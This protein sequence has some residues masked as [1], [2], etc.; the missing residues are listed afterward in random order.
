MR[1]SGEA[2]V[3]LAVGLGSF[4]HS[5]GLNDQ[6]G[7]LFVHRLISAALW[8]ALVGLGFGLLLALSARGSI[9]RSWL[10]FVGAALISS[11]VVEVLAGYDPWHLSAE[12]ALP[13]AWFTIIAIG[14]V[15]WLVQRV[16]PRGSRAAP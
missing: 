11:Y 14:G 12:W 16:L 6:T 5:A 7:F 4:L 15:A 13:E 8:V 10:L 1:L 9:F 3:P 2:A